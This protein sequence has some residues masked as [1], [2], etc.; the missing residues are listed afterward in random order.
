METNRLIW[1]LDEEIYPGFCVFQLS[2]KTLVKSKVLWLADGK[3]NV[4]NH[5]NDIY[6]KKEEI[7]WEG[8][9][10]RPLEISEWHIRRKWF[11]LDSLDLRLVASLGIDT[12]CVHLFTSNN[13]AN[14]AIQHFIAS[15]LTEQAKAEL[16]IGVFERI[17]DGICRAFFPDCPHRH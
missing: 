4:V 14:E 3:M 6:G 2:V 1:N 9:S 10:E 5:L 16:N 11:H 8:E 15:R 7:S 17:L 12:R 13:G